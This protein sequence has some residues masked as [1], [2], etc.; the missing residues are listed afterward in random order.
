VY[1]LPTVFIYYWLL[2]FEKRSNFTQVSMHYQKY[3]FAMIYLQEGRKE[4][5]KEDGR[6]KVNY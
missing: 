5:N 1:F 3:T 6:K 2:I 4:G